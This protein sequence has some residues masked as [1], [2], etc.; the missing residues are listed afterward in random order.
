MD[1]PVFFLNPIF[2]LFR[3]LLLADLSRRG[4]FFFFDFYSRLAFGVGSLNL[5]GV[6]T[7]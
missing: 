7:A 1:V 6:L 5:R 4:R 2:R 3:V